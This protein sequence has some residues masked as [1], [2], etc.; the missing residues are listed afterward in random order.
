MPLTG[1]HKGDLN[2]AVIILGSLCRSHLS[3]QGQVRGLTPTRNTLG[4]APMYLRQQIFEFYI[5]LYKF[6]DEC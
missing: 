2:S 3:D 5:L 6:S 1:H 4:Y